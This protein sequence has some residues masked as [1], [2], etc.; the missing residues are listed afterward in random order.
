MIREKQEEINKKLRE[1]IIV[2]MNL[3]LIE[4]DSLERSI[5]KSKHVEDLRYI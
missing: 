4:K 3:E 2:K 1:V 5:G